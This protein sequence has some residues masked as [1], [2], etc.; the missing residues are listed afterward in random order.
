[1]LDSCNT[2]G[3]FPAV[4]K[5]NSTIDLLGIKSIAPQR[6]L[7]PQRKI[8][9]KAHRRGR[10]EEQRAQRWTSLPCLQFVPLPAVVVAGVDDV[11]FF[12]HLS[13]QLTISY[14]VC[15]VDSRPM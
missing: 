1:M 12:T 3:R 10:G 11:A 13:N 7:R 4:L 5:W 14:R 9:P 2:A 8:K 15:S 6:T